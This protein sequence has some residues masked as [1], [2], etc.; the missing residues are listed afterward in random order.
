MER[1]G[2]YASSPKGENVKSHETASKIGAFVI[3]QAIHAI[4]MTISRPFS[5]EIASKSRPTI[6]HTLR[7]SSVLCPSQNIQVAP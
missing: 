3:S 5:H 7:H 6:P 1:S 4:E 2:I